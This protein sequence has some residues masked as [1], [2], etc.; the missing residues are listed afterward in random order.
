[1][2]ALGY[3]TIVLYIVF[4]IGLRTFFN[5]FYPLGATMLILAVISGT[6]L[7]RTFGIIMDIHRFLNSTTLPNNFRV[8]SSNIRDNA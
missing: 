2:D 5:D 6:L 4:E 8:S 1:M 7:G 3:I